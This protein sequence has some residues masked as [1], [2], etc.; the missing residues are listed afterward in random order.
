MVTKADF[1]QYDWKSIVQNTNA[2]TCS[3]YSSLFFNRAK[4]LEN[5][6]DIRG[7]DVFCLL[8]DITFITM[9]LDTPDDPFCPTLVY[10][11][12]RSMSIKDLDTPTIETLKELLPEIEDAQLKARIA[13]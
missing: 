12:R 2:K 10:D 4:E 1:D 11:F 6:G 8:G 9:C 5:S 7:Y 13:D 3:N